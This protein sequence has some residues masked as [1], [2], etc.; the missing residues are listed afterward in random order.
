MEQIDP[1][2]E[3]QIISDALE[4]IARSPDHKVRHAGTVLS[5]A[6]IR[7]C[8]RYAE[9]FLSFQNLMQAAE[10]VCVAKED[11]VPASYELN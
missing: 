1:M 6:F 10:R 11:D 7:R 5:D 4:V 9:L 8:T 2:V 3:A